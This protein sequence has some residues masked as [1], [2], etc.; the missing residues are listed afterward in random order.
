MVSTAGSNYVT[1]RETYY[2]LERKNPCADKYMC[3][4]SGFIF[5]I[6]RLSLSFSLGR[7]CNKNFRFF[8]I[9]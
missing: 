7:R 9:L 8:G 4:M 6:N 3:M 5:K 1:T 2:S